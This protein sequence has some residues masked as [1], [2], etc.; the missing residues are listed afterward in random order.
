M[1]RK[2]KEVNK[3][4]HLQTMTFPPFLWTMTGTSQAGRTLRLEPITM[5]RSAYIVIPPTEKE[6]VYV[7]PHPHAHK[8]TPSQHGLQKPC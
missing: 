5:Q 7:K 2:E 4:T 8:H 3:C 1:T 6:V